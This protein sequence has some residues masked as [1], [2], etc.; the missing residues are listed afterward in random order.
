MP[1]GVDRNMLGTKTQVKLSVPVLLQVVFLLAQWSVAVRVAL[2]YV[3]TDRIADAEHVFVRAAS[4]AGKDR[5]VTLG[6]HSSNIPPSA[7]EDIKFDVAG[8][9]FSLQREYFEFQK[10]KYAYNVDK[11]NFVQLAY[12]TQSSAHRLVAWKGHSSDRDLWY[13]HLKWGY[14]HFDIPL[15]SFLDLYLVRRG[16]RFKRNHYLLFIHMRF[17]NLDRLCCRCNK[18]FVRSILL[19]H[20]SCSKFY[21]CSSG[22]LTIIGTTASS[23][24]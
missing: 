9:A 15:P 17:E 2:G 3:S 22:V 1:R 20:F 24:C 21:V 6:R 10:V 16:I 5:I 8:V 19:R 13:G 18:N 11:K 7:T 14:N 12:P 23:L 4:N